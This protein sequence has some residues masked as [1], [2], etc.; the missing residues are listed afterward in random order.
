MSEKSEK[1]GIIFLGCR[2]EIV[3]DD[4]EQVAEV[5][6][7]TL[8]R[9]SYDVSVAVNGDELLRSFRQR[10]S[11]AAIV[12]IEMPVKDGLE[13][14]GELRAES[15]SVV[16]GAVSGSGNKS[17]LALERG[18]DASRCRRRGSSPVWRN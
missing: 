7:R 18:A 8:V 12:D 5:F 2:H 13:A 10:P 16:I 11:D 15:R 6:R 14:I 1:V 17:S 9:R 3:A 4:N